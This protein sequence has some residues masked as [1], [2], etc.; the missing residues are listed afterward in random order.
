MEK[1]IKLY[2]RLKV[3]NNI[4][5]VLLKYAIAKIIYGKSILAHQKATIKGIHKIICEGRLEV[6]VNYVGFMH[7]KDRTYL[8]IQGLMHVRGN[9]NIGR[10]CRFDVGKKGC[11]M[12]GQDTRINANTKVIIMHHLYIGDNCSISWDCQI[13][14]E[15]FHGFH[16]E[17]RKQSEDVI[18]IG[19]NVWIGCGV[20]IYK[21]TVIPDGCVIASDSIVKGVFHEKNCL[22]GGHPAKALKENVKWGELTS[23]AE[24]WQD[25]DNE[26]WASYLR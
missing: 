2:K 16:Y 23:F 21:G 26:Y 20:K 10:G 19:N 15:D 3:D 4:V 25:E 11:V 12:I 6:G 13:L 8:N 14:D 18:R 9:C 17:G 24:D 22:I 5:Y 1:L 7:R